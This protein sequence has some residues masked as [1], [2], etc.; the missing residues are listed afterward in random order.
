MKYSITPLNF[1][2]DFPSF[3]QLCQAIYGHKAA[4]CDEALHR[5]LFAENIYNPPG[6][7]FF[8][9]AKA[10]DKVIAS[11]C[12]M[13]VPF[14]IKG[15]SFRAAWSIK[16]MTHPDYQRQGIFKA[17]T[18]YNIAR[19]K[20]FG[21]DVILGIANAS[22]F[23]G[24]R[25]FG[26][27]ILMERKAIIRVLDIRKSLAKKKVPGPFAGAGNSLYRLLEKGRLARLAAQAR[28]YETSVHSSAP[29]V[30][31]E[32]W[33]KMQAAFPV[34]VERNQDYINWRYNQRPGQGYKFA[35][36]HDSGRAEALMIF[37][38]NMSEKYC[39]IVD[40]IGTSDSD[41][42]PALLYKVVQYCLENNLRYIINSSGNKFDNHLC[43]HFWF[44]H[45]TAPLVNNKF[46]AYRTN[47]DISAADL[48]QEDN[49][50]FSYGDTELDL[51]LPFA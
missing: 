32:I 37:R 23:A 16:T 4:A 1:E 11:D 25:K 38:Q 31:N 19:A 51:D 30:C 24:Y 28:K 26:W 29:D 42:I 27:D 12:L 33:P 8:T 17:L 44:R 7:H 21:I 13:P 9:V 41:A 48:K 46:I 18:E 35:L 39:I 36:A 14:H 10:G 20:E 34:A 45:L 2:R 40:Y 6:V 22:S 47:R 15:K 5:W 49:W 43:N 3:V 50:F